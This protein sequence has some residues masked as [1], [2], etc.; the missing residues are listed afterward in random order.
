MTPV[1]LVVQEVEPPFDERRLDE[2]GRDQDDAALHDK[3]QHHGAPAAVPEGAGRVRED[4]AAPGEGDDC[5]QAFR[6]AVGAG[7]GVGCCGAE[8]EEDGVAGLAGDEGAVGVEE[9]GV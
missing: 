2:A 8:A 1:D 6:P 5:E 7:C 9:G 4:G 3:T